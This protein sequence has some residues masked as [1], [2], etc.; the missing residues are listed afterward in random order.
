MQAVKRNSEPGMTHT[1]ASA[2][3]VSLLGVTALFAGHPCLVHKCVVHAMM[4]AQFSRLLAPYHGYLSAF[5][6][7]DMQPV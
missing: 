3:L 6:L 7:L 4:H 1:L 2:F 5:C